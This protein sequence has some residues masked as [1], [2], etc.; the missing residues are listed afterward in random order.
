[1]KGAIVLT[2]LLAL[3]GGGRA[4]DVAD[5]P[6]PHQATAVTRPAAGAALDA[7]VA[8]FARDRFTPGEPRY[9]EVPDGVSWQ[10]VVKP[11]AERAPLQRHA[12]RVRYGWERPGLDLI[13]VFDAGGDQGAAVAMEGRL[14][15]YYPVRFAKGRRR[16]AGDGRD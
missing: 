4:I 14:V 15:A 10:M 5:L 9:F 13:E 1:M 11:L 6:P 12:K 8:A 2:G 3:F 7:K 16:H